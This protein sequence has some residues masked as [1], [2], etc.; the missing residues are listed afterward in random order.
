ME[1]TGTI[2]GASEAFVQACKAGPDYVCNCCNRLMYRKTVTEFSTVKYPKVQA[3]IMEAITI[4]SSS[5]P[6]TNGRIWIC[7]TCDS[8][9]KRGLMPVQS[10]VN[11][12]QLQNIPSEL[13]DS[14]QL[15]TRLICLRI[16]FMKMVALPTG[17]Q[18]CIHGPAV[19]VPTD[20]SS[21][22]NLLPRLP[23]QCQILPMKL[24]RKLQYR[25]HYMYDFIRPDKVVAALEWL[26]TN[27]PLYKDISV[28][29]EW[30]EQA[31]TDNRTL[32]NALTAHHE[33]ADDIT[34]QGDPKDGHTANVT[35]DRD[36]PDR[37]TTI[38]KSQGIPTPLSSMFSLIKSSTMYTHDDFVYL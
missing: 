24:K 2:G 25:G 28:N 19:N 23:S 26:K 3:K 11:N 17:K 34:P 4:P 8:T 6:T 29:S 7:R 21:V 10:K 5:Y 27:N 31:A 18:R 20:L 38:R 14:N 37:S 32:W 22:C 33:D 30:V 36:L 1:V 12:L 9:L 15:E 13:Q 35:S 16:P